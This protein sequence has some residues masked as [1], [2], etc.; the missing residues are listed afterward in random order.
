VAAHPLAPRFSSEG[1]LSELV[2]QDGYQ[3]RYRVWTPQP[4]PATATL[5][6]L[7]GVMS[8]SLWFQ[9]LA[10]PLLGRGLK[11]VGADRRGTGENDLAR[12]DAPS[13]RALLDDAMAIVE[14]ERD[15][16]RPLHLVGW[17]WGAVLAIN[18]AAELRPRPSS[19]ILLAPGLFPTPELERR[20]AAQLEQ[21][22]LGPL[23]RP[24]LESPITDDMFT[25]G[26]ALASFIH[27]DPH[28]LTRFTPRFHSVM[29]RLA[30]GAHRKLP[31]LDLPL[32]VVLA[33]R[34]RATDNQRT[35]R[36]LAV[37]S[38]GRA[39]IEHVDSAH[40]MQFDAPDE[41]A[42]RV[43]AWVLARPREEPS[44]GC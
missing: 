13:G 18:L 36:G 3:L 21:A 42:A 30:M 32:L 35:E 31:V 14:R 4:D 27:R 7:N 38:A 24:C 44:D 1:R 26:P 8:H 28:R 15:P 29:S 39:V 23:D 10:E 2:S 9:S 43:A 34:D 11:L 22:R 6:L 33:K 20:M 37:L 5:V 12:G 16:E 19:L 40:G 17:C 41:L 25:D